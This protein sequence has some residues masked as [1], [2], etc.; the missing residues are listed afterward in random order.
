MEVSEFGE[1]S[2]AMKGRRVGLAEAIGGA[3]P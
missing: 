1:G 3:G 2:L